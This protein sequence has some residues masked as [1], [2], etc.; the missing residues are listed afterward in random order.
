MPLLGMLVLRWM[1]RI[2][3]RTG[4]K[5]TPLADFAAHRRPVANQYRRHL[6]LP[7]RKRVGQGQAD[8]EQFVVQSLKGGGQRAEQAGP[9]A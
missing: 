7:Y 8:A 6:W 4:G 1:H 2:C 9:G 3:R 5:I